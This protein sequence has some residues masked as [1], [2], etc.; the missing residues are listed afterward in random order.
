MPLGNMAVHRL[1]SILTEGHIATVLPDEQ[2]GTEQLAILRRMTPEQRWR[3]AHR[4]YWTCRRH[5]A[6]F[7]R[8]QHPD[9]SEKQVQDEV[10]N[11]FA[12]ART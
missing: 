3:A 5:K 12:N 2:P 11:L 9:W 1:A 4:L 8:S 7:L 6:A 10:R